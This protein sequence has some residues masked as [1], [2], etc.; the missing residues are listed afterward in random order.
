MLLKLGLAL[1]IETGLT[2]ATALWSNLA[3]ILASKGL[4][5][6][7]KNYQNKQHLQ[8]VTRSFKIELQI[9]YHLPFIVHA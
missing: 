6:S 1:T 2:C 3:S 9:W 8:S 7:Y 4:I 5:H